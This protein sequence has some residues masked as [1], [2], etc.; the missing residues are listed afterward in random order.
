MT[1]DTGG[2]KSPEGDVDCRHRWYDFEK[3]FVRNRFRGCKKCGREEVYSEDEGVWK[4]F[5]VSTLDRRI[6]PYN[7]PEQECFLESAKSRCQLPQAAEA[8]CGGQEV[9]TRGDAN[10]ARQYADHRVIHAKQWSSREV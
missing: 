7:I 6:I 9:V 10:S 1:T 4:S 3:F 8:S 5:R 2:Y